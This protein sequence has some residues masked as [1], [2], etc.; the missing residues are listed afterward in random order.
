MT[1]EQFKTLWQQYNF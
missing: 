1:L